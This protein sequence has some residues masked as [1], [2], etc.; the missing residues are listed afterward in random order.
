MPQVVKKKS[1]VLLV[2]AFFI[3][4]TLFVG[5]TF[6][7]QVTTN[8][9]QFGNTDNGSKDNGGSPFGNIGGS[10]KEELLEDMREFFPGV[11]ASYWKEWSYQ[12][13][14]IFAHIQEID[15][16]NKDVV[17]KINTP[18]YEK[19][20]ER[21]WNLHIGCPKDKTIAVSERNP[22]NSVV[23]YNFDVLDRAKVGDLLIG[24]CLEEECINIGNKCY[25]VVRN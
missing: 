4:I 22:S 9:G 13:K 20:S 15:A 5:Y 12:N 3:L 10:R 14:V 6:F 1:K 18:P 17:V 21:R 19:F 2:V 25:L 23:D 24:Y 16:V 11:N 8:D 7:P